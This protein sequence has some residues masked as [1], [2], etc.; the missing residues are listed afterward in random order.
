[1]KPEEITRMIA[2]EEQQMEHFLRQ[3]RK[4]LREAPQ[5]VW[6]AL[7]GVLEHNRGRVEHQDKESGGKCDHCRFGIT[8]MNLGYY[9]LLTKV[10]EWR[11]R[12]EL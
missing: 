4:K 12:G 11:E 5:D 10:Q 8:L 2:Q 9:F 1:M 6:D 3:T 7:S